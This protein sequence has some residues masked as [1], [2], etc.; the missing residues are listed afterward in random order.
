MI[1]LRN[2]KHPGVRTWSLEVERVATQPHHQSLHARK[3]CSHTR[4]G[5]AKHRRRFA[6]RTRDCCSSEIVST[7]A[8]PWAVDVFF[9]DATSTDPA[10][11]DTHD[12][13][14]ARVN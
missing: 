13:L 9:V 4:S 1:R 7:L 8:I 2:G 11:A 3:W 5:H 6:P 12:P 14:R 10:T